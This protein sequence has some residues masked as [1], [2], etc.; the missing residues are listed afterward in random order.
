MA[1]G[2]SI[3][4]SI[5]VWFEGPTGLDTPG[6]EKVPFLPALLAVGS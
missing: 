3:F 6:H 2:S 4:L 5:R 1:E